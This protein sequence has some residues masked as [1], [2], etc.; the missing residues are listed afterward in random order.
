MPATLIEINQVLEAGD[1]RLRPCVALLQRAEGKRLENDGVHQHGVFCGLCGIQIS[2]PISSNEVKCTLVTVS[3]QPSRAQAFSRV[4][5]LVCKSLEIQY[6][7]VK[8]EWR[9]R[10][11]QQQSTHGYCHR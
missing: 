10:Q 9:D 7:T 4:S 6:Q 5:F 1:S 2:V 11:V 3:D 8:A